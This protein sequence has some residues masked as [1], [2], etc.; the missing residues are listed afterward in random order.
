MLDD[1]NLEAGRP[2]FPRFRICGRKR[3]GLCLGRCFLRRME[4]P[5]KPAPGGYWQ[6]VGR[7]LAPAELLVPQ[8]LELPKTI[9]NMRKKKLDL[10]D[11]DDGRASAAL[12][13]CQGVRDHSLPREATTK[14]LLARACGALF[15]LSP[16][17]PSPAAPNI[18]LPFVP[19]DVS[20]CLIIDDLTERNLEIFQRLNGQKGKGTLRHVVDHTV[21]PMG[22]RHLEDMLRKLSGMPRQFSAPSRQSF[23]A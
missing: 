5:G 22:G 8:N 1:L 16:T 23:F 21:T 18:S 11:F 3:R 13:V 4:R 19:L 15:A 10:R 12:Q 2:E 7:K 14:P 17:R 6:W 20:R 9:G